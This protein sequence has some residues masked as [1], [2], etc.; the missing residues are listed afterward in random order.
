[1]RGADGTR[2]AR[3]HRQVLRRETMFRQVR[4]RCQQRFPRRGVVAVVAGDASHV[5]RRIVGVCL[6]HPVQAPFDGLVAA[7]P[8][9]AVGAVPSVELCPLQLTLALQHRQHLLQPSL[10][11]LM[12]P[13]LQRR[14]H[15]PAG[16]RRGR[17][18]LCRLPRL[19]QETHKQRTLATTMSKGGAPRAVAMVVSFC[20][21]VTAQTFHRSPIRRSLWELLGHRRDVVAEDLPPRADVAPHNLHGES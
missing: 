14:P 6:A 19:I 16:T 11:E 21:A 3:R 8:A 12:D 13:V 2:R 1:M 17:I 9:V 5:H 7:V 10:T 4:P 18:H 20:H 15:R